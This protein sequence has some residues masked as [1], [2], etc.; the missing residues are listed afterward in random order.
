MSYFDFVPVNPLVAAQAQRE[1]D[2]AK[3]KA[4]A[5]E[6][7]HPTPAKPAQPVEAPIWGPTLDDLKAL[8]RKV[9]PASPATT[10]LPPPTVPSGVSTGPA[11]DR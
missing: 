10:T 9:F 6:A 3:A 11:K 1:A 5:E 4:A 2:E 7:A 8:Y